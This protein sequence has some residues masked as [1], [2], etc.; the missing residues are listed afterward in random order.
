VTPVADKSAIA[1]PFTYSLE[2]EQR[3]YAV[4][5]RW[6][7]RRRTKLDLSRPELAEISGL[8]AGTIASIENEQQRV[9][10]HQVVVLDR[11][12]RHLTAA[13]KAKPERAEA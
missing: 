5:A 3:F 7:R 9:Y 13:A 11:T 8:S 10:V 2:A 1:Q 12:F 4:V 6:C